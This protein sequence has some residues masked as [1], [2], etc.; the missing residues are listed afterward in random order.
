K[1][2]LLYSIGASIA[3]V[4]IAIRFFLTKR[5]RTEEYFVLFS[6][7]CWTVDAAFI[8]FIV[9]YGGNS[10]PAERR[11]RI[12]PGSQ[13]WINRIMTGKMFVGA[14]IC[15]ITMIWSLKCSILVF[16]GRIK[17]NLQE[18]KLIKVTWWVLGATWLACILSMFL[19]CRPFKG[20]WQ[21]YPDPGS[22]LTASFAL[23]DVWIIGISN[24]LTDILLLAIPIPLVYRLRASPARKF[25]VGCI[26]SLGIFV[27]VA[28]IMRIY[29]TIKIG[30]IRTMAFWR[31]LETCTAIIVANCPGVRQIPSRS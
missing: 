12:I 21:I 15:Y 31:M 16:Y 13:E 26:F 7:L 19:V 3:I 22:K 10:I 23:E 17:E 14:W 6:L 25:M 30:C 5:L 18:Q 9:K 29:F 4:R 27:I 11:P 28:T 24:I 20:Y 8:P 1:T 2:W